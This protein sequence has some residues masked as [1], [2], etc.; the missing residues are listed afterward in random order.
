[1]QISAA[2]RVKMSPRRAVQASPS[3]VISNPVSARTRKPNATAVTGSSGYDERAQAPE[4]NI[5]ASSRTM[6]PE[7]PAMLARK[8]PTIRKRL[9]AQ[10]DLP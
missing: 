5:H 3:K 1:M 8:V 4:D 2:D 10:G 9:Q 6:S 7:K